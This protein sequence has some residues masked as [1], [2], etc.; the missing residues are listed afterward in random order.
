[1]KEKQTKKEYAELV[2]R[3]IEEMNAGDLVIA[4]DGS[5]A[6]IV[7]QGCKKKYLKKIK[8]TK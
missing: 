8:I 5:R 7:I 1:M 6:S 2:D 4:A 3:L